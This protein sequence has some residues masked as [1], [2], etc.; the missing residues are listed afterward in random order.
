MFALIWCAH[1]GEDQSYFISNI[2]PELIGVCVE[3]LIFIILFEQWRIRENKNNQI[4]VER[5]LREFLI[6]FLDK[7]CDGLSEDL[8]VGRFYGSDYIENQKILNK[9]I[10]HIEQHGLTEK[11]S[12]K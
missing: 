5:R 4:K 2:V 6:F 11:L 12:Y 8:T 7:A 9:F 1:E 3:L 10:E